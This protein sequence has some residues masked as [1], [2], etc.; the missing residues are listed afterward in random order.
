MV[1][2]SIGISLA[3]SS[4]TVRQPVTAHLRQKGPR[5]RP[6]G[7]TASSERRPHSTGS[8]EVK[9]G[10]RDA[11]CTPGTGGCDP[12]QLLDS[13]QYRQLTGTDVC[14]LLTNSGP[15]R[16]RYHQL[17][18]TDSGQAATLTALSGL[19]EKAISSNVSSSLGHLLTSVVFHRE[20]LGVSLC[21]TDTR[22]SPL[23]GERARC[24]VDCSRLCPD[25]LSI[26]QRNCRVLD[27]E[28]GRV[29]TRSNTHQG[30]RG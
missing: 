28:P 30:L 29:R 11:R 7:P 24:H 20:T 17:T 26:S 15:P 19:D 6:L 12:P 2:L 27:T 10:A 8:G 13:T 14:R 16:T 18:G 4:S 22:A 23:V 25:S 5:R 1:Q 9:E 3:F 21:T